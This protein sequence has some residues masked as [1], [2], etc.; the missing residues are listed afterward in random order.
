MAVG[1]QRQVLW[2]GEGQPLTDQPGQLWSGLTDNYLRVTTVVPPDVVLHN[3]T[4]ATQLTAVSG[5]T[6]L[7][8]LV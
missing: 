5:E 4:T 3:R 8:L 2:E 7:G 6:L 1:T